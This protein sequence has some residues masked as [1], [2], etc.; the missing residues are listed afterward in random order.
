[1]KIIR[2]Y[3]PVL[4]IFI[5]VLAALVIRTFSQDYFRP[6]SEKWAEP[7]AI[8]G[9][10]IMEEQL[11][12]LEGQLLIVDLGPEKLVNEKYNS[13]ILRISPDSVLSGDT[14]RKLKN[15]KGTLVLYSSE[16]YLSARLWMILSQ[17]GTK[18]LFIL[19]ATQSPE[20]EG[21]KNRPDTIKGPDQHV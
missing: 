6:D 9:N 16:N 4:L 19:P 7:S 18:N 2:K 21:Q 5:V 15:N 13:Y 11:D 1:M 14:I 8:S 20:I 12:E 3:W 10:I 17:T